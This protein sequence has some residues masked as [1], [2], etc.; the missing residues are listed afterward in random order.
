MAAAVGAILG[1]VAMETGNLFRPSVRTAI[2][3]GAAF[4]L[5]VVAFA[6]TPA[7]APA[8][9]LLFLLGAFR[10]VFGSMAQTL[11]QLMAPAHLRGRIIGVFVMAQSGLQTGSGATIGLLGA[12]VGVHWSLGLSGVAVFIASAWLFLYTRSAMRSRPLAVA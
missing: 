6:A 3:C 2:L 7:Y 5:V 9:A 8:V 10:L 1:G 11:V 4:G 12:V